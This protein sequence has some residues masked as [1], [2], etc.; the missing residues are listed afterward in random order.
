MR[1]LRALHRLERAAGEL[2]TLL[3][4]LLE[5]RRTDPRDDLLSH[6]ATA[7]ATGDET[8]GLAALLLLAGF[9]TTSALVGNAVAAMLD[10]GA[11]W[12]ELVADPSGVAANAVEEALRFDAPIQFTG[13]VPHVDVELGGRTLPAGTTVLAMLGAAGR[14]PA[15]HADPMLASTT[16]RR[17]RPGGWGGCG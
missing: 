9:E 14:D 5:R 16:A 11:P 3:A 7:E 2:R 1:S 13:R 10:A 15:V 17:G 4:G 8:V 6:L 12:A